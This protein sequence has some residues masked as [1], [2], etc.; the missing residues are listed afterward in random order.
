[1][2]LS[3]F[4]QKLEEY[5]LAIRKTATMR[6]P[7]AQQDVSLYYGGSKVETTP[8]PKIQTAFSADGTSGTNANN[9]NQSSGYSSS[10][11]SFEPNFSTPSSR[12]QSSTNVTSQVLQCN[13]TLNIQNG[14]KFSPDIAKQHMASLVTV[15]E[16]YESLVAGRI[17]NLMLTKED[18]DQIDSEELELMDIK[19]CLASVLRRAEKFKQ[20]TGKD[21]LREAAT[22]QLGFDKS[23]V[24]C[25]R[26]R[27]KG[28]FKRECTNR[29]AAGRQDPFRNNDYHRKAIYH[30][31]AQQPCTIDE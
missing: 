10:Y 27:E 3:K 11:T 23:K 16:S 19:W 29:E 12:Q 26:C 31:V 20:I 25:F 22:S 13:V 17:G 4:I 14:Q 15:L 2:N 24:T 5:E 1:M 6:S 9:T 28:H 18:Y 7:G 8:S 30:Q 21:D